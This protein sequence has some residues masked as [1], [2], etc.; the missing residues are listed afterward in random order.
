M[1]DLND[2]NGIDVTSTAATGIRSSVFTLLPGGEPIDAISENG[3]V[4]D[5]D[6]AFDANNDLTIDFGFV[7]AK[8]ATFSYWQAVNGLNGQNQPGQNGDTDSYNNLVEYALCMNPGSG[9]Q[10]SPAFCVRLNAGTNPADGKVEAFYTR[11]AGGGQGDITYTLEILRELSQSPSG[12]TTSTLTPVVTDNGDGTEKVFYPNL[13][14]EPV[15]AS[16]GHGFVRLRVTLTG[17]PNTGVTEVFGWNRRAFPVQ[18][19]TFA[20]PFLQKE[21]FSGVVDSINGTTIN[22]TTSAGTITLN[23]A[24]NASQP[25]FVEVTDG[26]NEG[27]RFELDEGAT[28]ATTLAIDAGNMRNTQT[29]LPGNLVGDKIVVRAHWTLNNLFP[30]TYFIAG[31]DSVTGD[32]LMFFNPEANNSDIIFMATVAGQRRWVLEGD[33]TQADAGNRILAPGEAGAFFV[34]PRNSPITMAF[35]GVVRANDFAMPLKVGSNYMGGG[36]P[37]D[38]SPN[39]RAMTVANGFTGGRS[40]TVADNFQFWKGDTVLHAEGYETHFLYNYS[41]FT[42]W[43]SATS[44]TLLSENDLKLF[45][46]MRGVVFTSRA[47]KANYVMPMPW[48]P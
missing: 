25:S 14:L 29:A 4:A 6:N 22:V 37:I 28:T 44:P 32:R 18:C 19:E 17:T 20:M 30:K 1:D 2:E 38:Q 39:D 31:P 3:L 16:A 5:A 41:G 43:Q 34:H 33:A 10:P 48:A 40:S 45:R 24:I 12:W 9:V 7:G 26:D 11:R 15:F 23:T 27:H 21:M 36:W 42:H 8:P 47:G 46:A 35:V 13:E